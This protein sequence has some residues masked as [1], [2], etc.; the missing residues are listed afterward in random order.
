LSS[1]LQTL[2]QVDDTG[3]LTSVYSTSPSLPPLVVN[4]FIRLAARLQGR[5]WIHFTARFGGVLSFGYNC[6]EGEPN[7]MKSG[8][9]SLHCPGLA[10]AHLVSDPRSIDSWRA[11]RIFWQVSNT[12]HLFPVCQI[13]QSLKKTY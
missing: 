13:S 7:W 9:L 8:A 3:R 4:V 12:F 2:K 1:T 11:G 6:A 10:L 5:Y